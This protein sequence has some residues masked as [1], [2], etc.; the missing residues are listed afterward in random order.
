M[1]RPLNDFNQQETKEGNPLVDEL[2]ESAK[3]FNSRADRWREHGD[4]GRKQEANWAHKKEINLLLNGLAN[5][6]HTRKMKELGVG[7]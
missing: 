7:R 4:G 5:H 3:T 6:C 1:R 2:K